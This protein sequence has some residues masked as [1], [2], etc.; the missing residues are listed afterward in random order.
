MHEYGILPPD[1][2]NIIQEEDMLNE[3]SKMGSQI[4][5]SNMLTDK[6]EKNRFIFNPVEYTGDIVDKYKDDQLIFAEQLSS[7]KVY[8][9]HN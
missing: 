9:T 7:T 8:L 4:F 6:I 1:E 5:D 2:Q 3:E